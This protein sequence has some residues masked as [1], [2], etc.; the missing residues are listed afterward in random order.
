[1][2]LGPEDDY[3]PMVVLIEMKKVKQCAQKHLQE[4]LNTKPCMLFVS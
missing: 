4:I 2:E 3:L 1:M